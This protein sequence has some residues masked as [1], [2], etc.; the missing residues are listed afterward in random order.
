MQKLLETAVLEER[1]SWPATSGWTTRTAPSGDAA[2]EPAQIH[3]G[4]G[5]RARLLR[6]AVQTAR[7]AYEQIKDLLGREILDQRFAG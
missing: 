3:G 7:E 4:G 1:K 6:L 2:A 5:Q